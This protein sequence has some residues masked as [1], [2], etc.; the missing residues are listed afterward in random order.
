MAS[1]IKNTRD[2]MID[3]AI[4][5][6]Q[7]QGY[8]GTGLNQIL[9]ASK[10]PRGSL[11]FHFPG[12]K[13]QLGAEAVERYSTAAGAAIQ[14]RLDASE[15][16]GEAVGGVVDLMA[17]AFERTGGAGCALAAVTL[18]SA[19]ESESL[20]AVCAEGFDHWLGYLE[21]RLRAAGREPAEAADEALAI[22]A[23]LE[24]ALVLARARRDPEPL[25][26]VA[27]RL[28]ASLAA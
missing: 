4:D 6:F 16:L 17:E 26:A 13:E 23:S 11:Y 24:G 22:L 27:R 3:T 28:R 25:R 19:S 2:R 8:D 5:L 18:D 21:G 9:A 14:H 20:R 15:D 1:E 7:R 12:G 10:A